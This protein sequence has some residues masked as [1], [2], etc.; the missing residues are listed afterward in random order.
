MSTKLLLIFSRPLAIRTFAYSAAMFAAVAWSRPWVLANVSRKNM[1]SYTRCNC[2]LLMASW[3]FAMFSRS[4]IAT[5]R[6][7]ASVAWSWKVAVQLRTL[8]RHS[9]RTSDP[10][11]HSMSRAMA[12]IIAWRTSSG[13]MAHN[14]PRFSKGCS[15]SFREMM[16]LWGMVAGNLK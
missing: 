6:R 9:S 14:A 8:R 2:D 16:I 1:I 13:L 4:C 5:W 7:P 15:P 12:A 3:S 10:T 11:P